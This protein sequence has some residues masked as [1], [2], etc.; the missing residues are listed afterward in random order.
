LNKGIIIKLFMLALLLRLLPVLLAPSLPIALDD[1]FQYDMLAKSLASDNGFKWYNEEDLSLIAKHI[2]VD[3]K[4]N[5]S[6]SPAGIETSFRAPAYPFFL[7]IIYRIFGLENRHFFARIIQTFLGA[8]LA[9]LTFLLFLQIY[10]ENL[11]GAKLAGTILAMYPMLIFYPLALATEN[12][13]FPLFN[14]S[15]YLVTLAIN[16]KRNKY[17]MMAGISIGLTA[18]TRSVV[19][20]IL[21]LFFIWLVWQKFNW[22]KILIF[23]GAFTLVIIPWIMRNS[24]LHNSFML[25]ESSL[26]YNLYL[27]YHPEGEGSFIFGPS[28]DLL[29]YL[30]DAARNEAGIE[31]FKTF[32]SDNP[33]RVPQLIVNKFKAFFGLEKKSIAYFYSNNLFGFIPPPRLLL[34]FGILVF[35]FIV[36][37]L[38]SFFSLPFLDWKNQLFQSISIFLIGYLIPHLLI[39][40]EPRFHLALVPIIAI[41]ASHWWYIAWNNPTKVFNKA[42]KQKIIIGSLTALLMITV[43]GTE[44]VRDTEKLTILFGPE[45]NVSRMNYE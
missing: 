43:W 31:G 5:Q 26:G 7:S 3:W 23:F 41:F 36:I 37:T 6:Y 19:L 45:G 22:K 2:D 14:L 39:L 30:D 9:P 29:P 13:F 16:H 8:S 38:F 42:N 1:M 21:P 10:P 17:F 33:S 32:V 34:A 44:L 28:L 25:I 18:L 12:L 15:L 24:R 40:A 27:G 35:P 20:A 4:T 11:K